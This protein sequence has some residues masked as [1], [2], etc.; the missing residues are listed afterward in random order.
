MRSVAMVPPTRSRASS[1]VSST[2]RPRSRASSVAR[3]AAASP[4][5]PP[6]TMMNF[7]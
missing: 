7:M 5:I 1:S 2:A 3:W 4:A 6:P